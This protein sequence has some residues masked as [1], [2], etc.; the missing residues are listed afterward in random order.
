MSALEKGFVELRD[1]IMI[2]T[3]QSFKIDPE[4][5]EKWDPIMLVIKR[6]P[7]TN[8]R[9][10]LN[11]VASDNI[12]D[13]FPSDWS[14]KPLFSELQEKHFKVLSEVMTNMFH[15]CGILQD[16]DVLAIQGYEQ[17]LKAL[18][19]HMVMGNVTINQLGQFLILMTYMSFCRMNH[20][21]DYMKDEDA[22]NLEVAVWMSIVIMAFR[23]SFHAE[24]S[25]RTI[26]PYFKV[27]NTIIRRRLHVIITRYL[28]QECVCKNHVQ[29]DLFPN[30]LTS[31]IILPSYQHFLQYLQEKGF[32]R[33]S[34]TNESEA[35]S[36]YGKTITMIVLARVNGYYSPYFPQTIM[37]EEARCLYGTN[38]SYA[39]RDFFTNK[40]LKVTPNI[41]KEAVN[42][43]IEFL[44]RQKEVN[45]PCTI[46]TQK[47]GHEWIVF[48]RLPDR[49]PSN[50]DDESHMS[51]SDDTVGFSETEENAENETAEVADTTSGSQNHEDMEEEDKTTIRIA[52]MHLVHQVK[53]SL[54]LILLLGIIPFSTLQY[55]ILPVNYP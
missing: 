14:P 27:L 13:L 1:V 7:W 8:M 37:E 2:R 44:E 53:I 39:E 45:C 34:I 26:N 50:P 22:V 10:I 3:N 43:S 19:H 17:F 21:T 31:E 41:S 11:K 49:I 12:A 48:N 15:Q 42:Q 16:C 46:H 6:S 24:G 18:H 32:S 4:L 9:L 5:L 51:D 47:R 52:L 33:F 40:L 29:C 20:Y 30:T 36:R 25:H 54:L 35:L 55:L 38:F 28:E 23:T